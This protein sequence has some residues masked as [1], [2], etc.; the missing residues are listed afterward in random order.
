M[1]VC[2]FQLRIESDILNSLPPDDRYVKLFNYIGEQYNGNHIALVIIE[3]DIF[4]NN[5]IDKMIMLTDSLEILDFGS[6][7]SLMTLTDIRDNNGIIEISPLIDR[8]LLP[9]SDSALDSLAEYIDSSSDFKGIVI[10]DDMQ[11]AMII[12]KIHPSLDKN[13]AASKIELI[14]NHFFPSQT[15]FGGQ[16]FII[17]DINTAILKDLK[18]LIPL[19]CIIMVIVLG[20]SF[21]SWRGIFLP[22]L[23][24]CISIVWTMGIMAIF[25]RPFTLISNI[26]PV[27]LLAVGSAYSIHIL[28]RYNEDSKTSQNGKQCTEK[29][30]SHVIIPVILAGLTTMVGFISFIFGSYLTLIKDFGIFTSIGVLISLLISV[31]F[32]PALLSYLPMRKIHGDII[33]TPLRH[34]NRFIIRHPAS[35]LI[36]C[37]AIFTIMTTGLFLIERSVDIIDYFDDDTYIKQSESVIKEKFGGSNYIQIL[38]NGNIRDSVNLETIDYLASRLAAEQD[39]Y[40]VNSISFIIKKMNSIV[41]GKKAIPSNNKIN[42]LYFLIE[43]DKTISNLINSNMKETLIQASYKNGLDIGSVRHFIS[44]YV[45]LL[46]SISSDSLTFSMSGMPMLYVEIDSSIIHSQ[47]MS[48]IIASALILIIL[49]ILLRNVIAGIV[50]IIPILF[51][52]IVIF[53]FM[54][55]F[56]LPLDIATA[57]VGSITIGIGID[58]T[59]HFLDRLKKEKNSNINKRILATLNSSGV[60]IFINMI[61]VVSGFII[62]VFAELVPLRRFG[63]LTAITMISSAFSATTLLPAIILLVPG[64]SKYFT[65]GNK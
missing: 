20:I 5:V 41:E 48:L 7:I 35:I 54:G 61:T 12:V 3:D 37:I 18:L 43:G 34:I 42:N 65:G 4:S 58:Y 21:R 31:T 24:V 15:R 26:I 39:I 56:N 63:M 38:A 53:G 19:L 50:G 9:F 36:I 6:I 8:E 49:S 29:A 62:L 47:I 32:M 11:S 17:K 40:N 59:I 10:S 51:T 46:D 30:L 28:N 33:F 13:T 16:P 1:S 45:P 60:A 55:I 22:L 25:N 14:S 44:K 64:L 52:L 27:I 2:S 57:L 23:S